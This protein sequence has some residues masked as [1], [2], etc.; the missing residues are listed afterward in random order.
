MPAGEGS[1]IPLEIAIQLSDI[2]SVLN[3]LNWTCNWKMPW[4][5][6]LCNDTGEFK[7]QFPHPLPL[8]GV[9]PWP[10]YPLDTSQVP[11]CGGL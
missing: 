7:S 2:A 6:Y 10:G 5:H 4:W 1:L 11:S 8:P 3:S 9:F